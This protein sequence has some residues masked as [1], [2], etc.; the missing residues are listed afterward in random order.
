[1]LNSVLADCSQINDIQLIT[2]LD[3]RV[4]L[5]L[6]NIE[7]HLIENSA[8]YL[9]TVYRLANESNYTWIIAPESEGVLKSLVSQLEK[10][11]I[12]VI[13]CDAE[14]IGIAGDKIKCATQLSAAGIK[15]A[16]NL[17][18]SEAQQYTGKVVIKSRFGVGCEGLKICDSGKSGL[19]CIDDFNN[20]VVQPCIDGEH[21]SLSLLCFAGNAK[22][23]T[24]NRQIFSGDLEPKLKTCQVN[25]MPVTE[26]MRS[27][28]ND[29]A[30]TLPGLTGYVGVDLIKTGESYV[31]IDI[32]PRL[33]SSYAGLSEVLMDNPA[34]LCI[35]TVLDQKLPENIMQQNKI[36]EVHL[37]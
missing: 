27:I 29:I 12:P 24:C 33:T 9:T 30:R 23:L 11:K 21:L 25:A 4:D 7:N 22:T 16:A 14:S 18:Y 8:D 28:S 32:N 35:R 1:M 36:V 20:W 19:A 17:S 6:N 13:N 3:S 15:T 10:E 5:P 2:C 34:E 31:V 26:K 37:G